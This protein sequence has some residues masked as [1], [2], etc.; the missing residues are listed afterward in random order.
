MPKVKKDQSLV[1]YLISKG[2]KHQDTGHAWE[3][4]LPPLRAL[5]TFD[6]AVSMQKSNDR[7]KK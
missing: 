7:N 3:W 1:D 2:W 6:D 5:Y 4:S